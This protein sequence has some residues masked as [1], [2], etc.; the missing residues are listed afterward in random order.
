VLHI[1]WNRGNQEK[2]NN[3][4]LMNEYVSFYLVRKLDVW[5]KFK[6]VPRLIYIKI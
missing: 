6:C 1:Y 5:L 4:G 3:K 2:I